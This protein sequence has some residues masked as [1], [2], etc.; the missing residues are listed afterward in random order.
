MKTTASQPTLPG[1][2]DWREPQT[3]TA[4]G[5]ARIISDAGS[6]GF[7]AVRMEARDK[8]LGYRVTFQRKAKAEFV[9]P[10]VKEKRD[11]SGDARKV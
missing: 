11:K 5:L 9:P 4:C 10:F 1:V 6:A 7:E 2:R 3:V 8:P